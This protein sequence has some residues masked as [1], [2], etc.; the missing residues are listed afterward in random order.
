MA[1]VTSGQFG[2]AYHG[3]RWKWLEALFVAEPA[4]WDVLQVAHGAFQQFYEEPMLLVCL[5]PSRLA[6]FSLSPSGTSSCA[7]R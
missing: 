3:P 1:F 7:S 6:S 4:C 5:E 2:E